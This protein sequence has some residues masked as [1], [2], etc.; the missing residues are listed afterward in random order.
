MEGRA[1][2]SISPIKDDELDLA[3]LVDPETLYNPMVKTFSIR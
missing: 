1:K 2:Y 3:I